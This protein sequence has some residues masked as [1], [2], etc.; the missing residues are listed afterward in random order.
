MK[1]WVH[2]MFYVVNTVY[3]CWQLKA[4]AFVV[5]GTVTLNMINWCKRWEVMGL[6]MINQLF[7]GSRMWT[8]AL[9]VTVLT[10][11]K[12][13]I[14]FYL[15]TLLIRN[16]QLFPLIRWGK[17]YS[18]VFL[19]FFVCCYVLSFISYFHWI[20]HPCWEHWQ[21][22]YWVV[23]P[24]YFMMFSSAKHSGYNFSCLMR[25]NMAFRCQVDTPRFP[26]C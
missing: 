15:V 11:S 16:N 21:Q 9:V 23:G 1:C 10:S 25:W 8:L 5:S 6:S 24:C 3:Q 19:L 7:M 26:D 22:W 18:F 12:N 2:P 17:A 14:I 20:N 4:S 13:Y